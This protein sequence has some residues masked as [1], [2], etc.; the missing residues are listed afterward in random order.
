[1]VNLPGSDFYGHKFGGLDNPAIMARVVA[2]QDRQVG[3]LLDAYRGAGIFDQT[4]FV[5]TADHG[6]VPNHHELNP[7]M[8]SAV[9]QETGAGFLFHTGGTGKYVYLDDRSMRKAREVARGIAR[10]PT[11]TS[12]YFRNGD[13]DYEAAGTRPDPQLDAAYRYLFSTFTGPRGPDVVASYRENTIG[14]VYRHLYGNHG[15]MSWGVQQIPLLLAGPGVRRG[16]RSKAPARLVDVAPTVMRL[17][18]MNLP[19]QDG[20]VLADA[21]MRPT[22]EEVMAQARGVSTLARHQE[23]LREL[24]AEETRQ[25]RKQGIRPLPSVA[26]AP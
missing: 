21:L 23:A 20:V 11:I 19:G 17:L 22:A 13:G 3:K 1:M 4:L 9:G 25:D 2:G 24:A 16:V 7:K 15:G 12:A 10:L 8:V 26:V 14:S 6:M 18:G 5:L